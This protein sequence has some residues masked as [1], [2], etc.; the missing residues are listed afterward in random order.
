MGSRF[1]AVCCER[2]R[3]DEICLDHDALVAL[4]EERYVERRICMEC[5]PQHHSFD[6]QVIR[7]HGFPTAELC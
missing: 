7:L 3:I 5:W 4:L 1:L 2:L 6:F